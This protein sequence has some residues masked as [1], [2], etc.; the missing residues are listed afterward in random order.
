MSSRSA[1]S[2]VSKI[3]FAIALN[4]SG[5]IRA[6]ESTGLLSKAKDVFGPSGNFRLA[7]FERGFDFSPQ[8][9]LAVPALWLQLRPKEVE[10]VR[11]FF[12]GR[13][14]VA[15][16]TRTPQWKF[17]LREGYAEATFGLLD[18]R[19][20]RQVVVWGRAD[21]LNP[22]DSFATRDLTLLTTDDE[23][24]RLGTATLQATFNFGD[25]RLISVWQPEWRR[26][27]YPIPPLAGLVLQEQDPADSWQQF[28]LKLDRSGGSV[29]WSISYASVYDRFP[30][31]SVVGAGPGGATIGLAHNRIHVVGADLA[32]TV[33]SVGLRAEA[34][35]TRT[36]D[37]GGTDPTVKNA[38]LYGVLG[39]E[40]SPLEN[41]T[42]NVQY[43]YR[44][45]FDFV[46]P[47]SVADPNTQA[48]ALQL[49]LL[50]N[51]MQAD[52]HG[53]SIR[54]GYKLLHETLEPELAFVGYATGG[55]WLVRPKVTYAL[56]DGIKLITGATFFGGPAQSFFG[57]LH[58]T[59]SFF[60]EGRFLF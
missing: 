11:T 58:D 28:G 52:Q 26:P 53:A 14:V 60:L 3:V 27:G 19:V 54:V 34:A 10:G 55:G 37:D 33:G 32:T 46:A 49:G 8:R 36:K 50:S 44:H 30:D 42:V 17:D 21:K 12:E 57:R 1:I 41:L 31:L 51:Q 48:L 47:A 5:A 15:D 20:G 29:D 43:L 35:Y 18:L 6:D 40:Y 25:F 56:T 16:A 45:V 13:L 23:E 22:T 2:S 39:V 38:T 7:Y 9:H 59:S 4:L 24:Q